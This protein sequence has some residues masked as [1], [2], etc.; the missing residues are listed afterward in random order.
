MQNDLKPCPFC[1]K[2]LI[3]RAGKRVNRFY[4][5][6]PTIYYHYS[7]KCILDG[8]EITDKDI[9]KWNRRVKNDTM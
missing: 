3:H 4:N 5:G 2:K 9:D 1:G 8:I 6:E 7:P